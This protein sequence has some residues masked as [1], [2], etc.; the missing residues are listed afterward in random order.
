[1]YK[2]SLFIIISFL[3]CTT[4]AQVVQWS[5]GYTANCENPIEREDGT[6]LAPEEIQKVVYQIVSGTSVIYEV[7]MSGGCK[8]AFIDTK[9]YIP[10]GEYLLHCYTVDTDERESALSDP[11]VVLTVQKARPKPPSGMR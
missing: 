7:L 2:L 3:S 5:Q 4:N 6:A 9:Q 1:M 11:G 8:A 10:V